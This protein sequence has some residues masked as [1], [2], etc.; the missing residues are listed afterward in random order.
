MPSIQG[1]EIPMG[2][3]V[4]IMTLAPMLPARV[5]NA[6]NHN[7][8]FLAQTDTFLEIPVLRWDSAVYYTDDPDNYSGPPRSY[9]KLGLQL[10]H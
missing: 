8:M 4:N 3:Q 7:L 2:D 6:A 9:T 10:R 5:S 1:Q